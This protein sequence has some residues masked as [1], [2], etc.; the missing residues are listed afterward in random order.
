[1]SSI[2]FGRRSG[3][4]PDDDRVVVGKDGPGD[5]RLIVGKELIPKLGETFLVQLIGA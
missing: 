3:A 1:M 5:D 4:G 2:F